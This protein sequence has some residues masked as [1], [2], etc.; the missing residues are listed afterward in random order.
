MKLQTNLRVINKKKAFSV[1]IMLIVINSIA[2][3][4]NIDHQNN[5]IKSPSV[6][7]METYGAV[8][9][10][11]A[12]G[13]PDISIPLYTIQTGSINVPVRLSY[14]PSNVRV[15]AKPGWLGLGWNLQTAG[16][17]TRS[18]YSYGNL[19]DEHKSPFQSI[20][21]PSFCSYFIC[22]NNSNVNGSS[23]AGSLLIEDNPKWTNYVYPVNSNGDIGS[24]GNTDEFYANTIQADSYHFS[25][26][27]YSGSFQYAGP[28]QGWVV[29]SDDNIKVEQEGFMEPWDVY[30]DI[31]P[32]KNESTKGE[33]P[34]QN[35][36]DKQSRFFKKFILTTPDGTRYTFGGAN[37]IEY[38]TPYFVI[39]NNRQV[40]LSTWHL[41]KIEDIKHN[42]VEFEYGKDYMD[43]DL[44]AFGGDFT[45]IQV[46]KHLNNTQGGNNPEIPNDIINGRSGTFLF[47][48]YLSKIK[49]KNHELS[50]YRSVS[51]ELRYTEKELTREYEIERYLQPVGYNTKNLQRNK[52]DK[53]WILD[54]INNKI[55]KTIDFT[56]DED[57]TKRLMLKSLTTSDTENEYSFSYNNT[58]VKYV[59]GQSGLII[60]IKT[61]FDSSSFPFN[62]DNYSRDDFDNGIVGKSSAFPGFS[63]LSKITYPTKGYTEFKWEPHQYDRKLGLDK[64]SLEYEFGYGS[65]SR[66]AEIKNFTSENNLSFHKKFLYVKNYGD[67]RNQIGSGI[68]KEAYREFK[69]YFL[70]L[71]DITGLSA[72]VRIYSIHSSVNY[73]SA[74]SGQNI[75][76]D[77]VVEK[78]VDGSYTKHFF[79]SFDK[80]INGQT[81]FDIYPE[82]V[83]T[84]PD[85]SFGGGI[86]IGFNTYDK[87]FEYTSL[88]KERGKEVAT[89]DYNSNNKI[90]REERIVF[91]NDANRFKKYLKQIKW[92]RTLLVQ[93][94]S[95]FNSGTLFYSI[96]L[97]LFNYRYFPVK[98]TI[99]TYDTNDNNPVVQSKDFFYNSKD[100]LIVEKETLS[101]GDVLFKRNYYPTD[102]IADSNMA[103][104]VEKNRIEN[105]I[106][107]QSFRNDDKLY[108]ENT[109]YKP[110][111][112]GSDS[113]LMPLQ[114]YQAKFPNQFIEISNIGKLEAKLTYDSYDDNGNLTQYTNEN[115]I[116]T[117]IIW[118]YQKSV[119]IAKIEKAT[120]ASV[121]TQAANLQLL[122]DTKDQDEKTLIDKLNELRTSLPNAF[123]TTYTHKPLVGVSTITDPKGYT[124]YYYYD[125]FNKLSLVKDAKGNMINQN[126]YNYKK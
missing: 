83:Y 9:V 115:G 61:V 118:G 53:I 108:E 27:N 40:H 95:P 35:M 86:L 116:S 43:C 19:V 62:N 13:V 78:N 30:N 71:N 25:F 102:L 5:N 1:I 14:H 52:L 16:Y 32:Y 126:F 119:P 46:K 49:T 76:Y 124:M 109:T 33:K 97:K 120:Y 66:I 68:S 117:V 51:N 82:S 3:Q 104:L 87:F 38:Y 125:S 92:S 57:P 75:S 72:D 54:K 58:S 48:I 122:T 29:I 60:P 114:E 105:P 69:N 41:I 15:D 106:I 11:L 93:K 73:N 90:V 111:T 65:G 18:N 24:N 34:Y 113:V 112:I 63:L 88:E 94:V 50:F 17:I 10:R 21:N 45:E 7:N 31:K 59:P 39:N 55:I 74:A 8:P 44:S 36:S 84:F 12:T 2:Q 47:P 77:E 110:V 103:K 81:H 96:A 121:A 79:T 99:T 85:Q 80:D 37:A 26:S 91:N 100:Q 64:A 22:N 101:D 23:K 28:R 89:F 67:P 6:A 4:I 107:K 123:V 98:K 70:K 20:Q 56:Y 42:I